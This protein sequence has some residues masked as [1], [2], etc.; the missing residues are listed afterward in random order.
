[1]HHR[2]YAGAPKIIFFHR[3]TVVEEVPHRSLITHHG[4]WSVHGNE[5]IDLTRL[6]HD[7]EFWLRLPCSLH[8]IGKLIDLIGAGGSP[9]L[10]AGNP[11]QLVRLHSV[12]VHQHSARPDCSAHLVIAD[13]DA[14]A[15]K[16][17]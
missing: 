6:K 3:S 1:M 16:L 12:I 2:E 17:L 14:L 8:H 13:A 5:G 9:D 7:F 15:A 4:P 11:N 10:H